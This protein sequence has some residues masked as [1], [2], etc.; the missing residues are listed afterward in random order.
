[1]GL[2][3]RVLAHITRDE[4]MTVTSTLPLLCR[5]RRHLS[6]VAAAGMAGV[7]AT[8]MAG[9]PA[10]FSSATAQIGGFLSKKP[11]APPLWATHLSPM[12]CHTFSLGHVRFRSPSIPTLLLDRYSLYPLFQISYKLLHDLDAVFE[13]ITFV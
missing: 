2:I 9:V 5:F 6:L 7:T 13:L 11:Y 10:T 3:R 8:G 4:P 1:L 12:P